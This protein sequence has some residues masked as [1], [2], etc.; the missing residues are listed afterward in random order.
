MTVIPRQT[1]TYTCC[2]DYCFTSTP[3][4][5]ARAVIDQ[6][7]YE[8]ITYGPLI[9]DLEFQLRYKIDLSIL[10]LECKQIFVYHHEYV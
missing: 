9:H 2:V 3:E 10:V 1:K 4:V 8:K 7:G 5:H 6:L